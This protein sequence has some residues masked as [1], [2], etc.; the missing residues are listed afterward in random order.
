VCISL[1]PVCI[2]L[3][4]VSLTLL[5]SGCT[6]PPPV[7][8]DVSG[9]ASWPC[10]TNGTI[11][12]NGTTC[13]L[14]CSPPTVVVQGVVS[15][16]CNNG[17]WLQPMGIGMECGEGNCCRG[18]AMFFR[19]PT[20]APTSSQLSSSHFSSA[21]FYCPLPSDSYRL[22]NVAAV[23]DT[24]LDRVVMHL[25]AGSFS[26]TI[27]TYLFWTI[28]RL[29]DSN[30]AI[31]FPDLHPRRHAGHWDGIPCL[32]LHLSGLGCER[33]SLRANYLLHQ[34]MIVMVALRRGF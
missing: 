1:N 3:N 18:G 2:S 34:S 15:S 24:P 28:L 10:G 13:F 21:A 6:G 32:G 23:I 26:N 19:S 11:T 20:V 27:C 7:Y 33:E 31:L 29:T 16:T 25:W 17:A 12:P 5:P 22:F 14:E 4:A 8:T 30:T 9:P